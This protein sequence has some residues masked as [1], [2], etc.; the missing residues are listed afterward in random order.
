MLILDTDVAS[1][2]AKAGHFDVLIKLF[3]S[4]GITPSVYEELLKPLKHGYEYPKEIFQKTELVTISEEEQKE[5]LKLVEK[6]VK[7]GRG[8]TESIIVCLKRGYSFSSFDKKAISAVTEL[9]VKYVTAGAIFKG[10]VVKGIAT[11]EEVLRIIRDIE[12]S[13]NRVLEVE[14]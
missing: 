11:K 12:V 10:L 8:E 3:G 4:V 14:L 7:I 2:F 13:D 1:A 9:G 6:Y 5:Y